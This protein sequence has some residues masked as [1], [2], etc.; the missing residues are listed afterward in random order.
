MTWAPR[1]LTTN[2]RRPPRAEVP[3]RRRA[4][5]RCA[6][7]AAPPGSLTSL[8]SLT[9]AV[10]VYRDRPGDESGVAVAIAT[11]TPLSSLQDHQLAAPAGRP[12][13]GW[14]GRQAPCSTVAPRTPPAKADHGCRRLPPVRHHL[15]ATRPPDRPDPHPRYRRPRGRRRW[16][17]R[18]RNHGQSFDCGAYRG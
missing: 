9:P 13:H 8:T 7:A 12:G 18:R 1:W 2:S 4:E 5:G 16:P 3:P 15:A 10:R 14:A 11:A 17:R 6:P